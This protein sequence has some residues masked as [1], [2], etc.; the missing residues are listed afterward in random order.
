MVKNL[1][2]LGVDMM[3]RHIFGII[4]CTFLFSSSVIPIT[5][6]TAKNINRAITYDVD[7][8]IWEVGD[9]W[10]YQYTESMT[11]F[12]NYT[13]SGD[14]KL[15]VVDDSGDYYTL[16]GKSRPRGEFNGDYYYK[17]L[18]F[19]TT[20]FTTLSM[21]IQL[22]KSDLGVESCNEKIKGFLFAKIGV[23]TIPIPLQFEKYGDVRFEPTWSI[24]PFPL[25]DGKYG[26]LSG[27]EIVFIKTYAHML[28]GGLPFWDDENSVNIV[29]PIP[30]TCSAEEVTVDAGKFDVLKVSA[31]A[32]DGSSFVSYFSEEVRNVVRQEICKTFIGGSLNHY[33]ILELKDWNYEQ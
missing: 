28:W 4:V 3:K 5:S 26:N 9:S 14:I 25:Y 11:Y 17:G 2:W 8:P 30:Y 22:R 18:I 31:E 27:T 6:I 12:L 13:L 20:L 15:K 21:R 16:E 29:T 23:I 33:L 1:Y 7:V 24:M 10:T 32:D 19:K